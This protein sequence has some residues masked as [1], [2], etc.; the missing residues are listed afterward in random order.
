M[1]KIEEAARG[2]DWVSL[3][4]VAASLGRSYWS[5][6]H[7]ADSGVLGSPLIVGQVQFFKREIVERVVRERIAERKSKGKIVPADVA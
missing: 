2:T 7:L 3:R 5:A 4:E 6:W 1:D